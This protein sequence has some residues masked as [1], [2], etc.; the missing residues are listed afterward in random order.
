MR[1]MT[2]TTNTGFGVPI[3]VDPSSKP[4][5]RARGGKPTMRPQYEAWL[6]QLET[7]ADYEMASADSDGAHPVAR[8]NALRKVAK[9]MTTA[10]EG[11]KVEAVYVGNDRKRVRIFASHWSSNGDA[12][13]TKATK[14][15]KAAKA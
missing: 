4:A 5:I 11:F 7:G 13:S 10:T 1:V 6:T 8:L 15:T 3:K 9:E 12:E 2:D 14:A